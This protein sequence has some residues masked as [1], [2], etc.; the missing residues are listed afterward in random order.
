M[1]GLRVL[2]TRPAHQS[3]HLTEKL[4]AWGAQAISFPTIEI[5]TSDACQNKHN[6]HNTISE[7]DIAL[8]VSQNAVQHAFKVIDAKHLPAVLKIGVIGKGSLESLSRFGIKANDMPNK[9]YNS[10]GLL[11]SELLNNVNEKN[12]IIFRGQAGRN[13]LG[14]TLQERGAKVTY[15]EVYQRRIPDINL[16]DYAQAFKHKLNIALFTSSE[17]LLNAFKMLKPIDA[18]KLLQTPWLLISERMKKTA[19]DLGH[20][21]DII[22]AQ[23]AS[24]DG[25]MSTL[26]QWALKQPVNDENDR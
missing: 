3:Q 12:I 1:N 11:S 15:C 13:L 20:N 6:I 19:Y 22:I 16:D 5:K 23:Q 10:E 7:Y 21:S 14:D 24:D 8:F 25:I 26:K 4:I 2:N 17:G 18:D 9:T